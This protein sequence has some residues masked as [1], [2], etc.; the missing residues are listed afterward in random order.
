MASDNRDR[1]RND[2]ILMPRQY[3]MVK[4][5]TKG[6]LS[7]AVGPI[8]VTVSET[9]RL[10]APD[11]RNPARLIEVN[12]ESA[13][14]PYTDVGESDYVV[15]S[16]PAKDER[17]VP[18]PKSQ[19]EMVEL[20]HG[21]K[22]N[23]PGPVSFPLWPFQGV[24][25]IK[26]HQ[27]Q[28]N[29][30][31]VVRVVNDAEAL[32]NWTKSIVKTVDTKGIT[33]PASLS[34]GQLI[35]IKGT[36]VSFYIPPTGLEVVKDNGNKYVRDAVTLE[37]LEYCV[38]V[39]QNGEKRFEQGPKVVFPTATEEFVVEDNSKKFKAT[40]LTA[41]SG[42]HIKVTAPY[43]EGDKTYKVG[44]ELFVTGESTPIYYPRAEH[45]LV[46]YGDRV[47]H[48]ATAIPK[49]EG[50]YVMNRLT[51]E[52]KLVR[53]PKM[54]LPDP[55]FEVIV[56]RILTESQ[57]ALWYPGNNE[58]MALNLS[59]SAA[60]ETQ[61]LRSGDYVTTEDMDRLCSFADSP[62][63]GAYTRAYAAAAA[64]T[65]L[66]GDQVSRKETYTP[67]RTVT[68]NTKYDGAVQINVWTGYAVLVVD[69][70]GNRQIVVG[71]QTVLLEFD[72]ELASMEFSTGKP[73]STD[74]LYKTAYLRVLNNQVS[75][76][77]SA[78]TADDIEVK[79]KT[80]YRVNFL[81]ESKEN[82]FDAE[83]YVKL[84]CDHARS[85]LRNVVKKLGI[86]EFT[87]KY[88]DLVRDTVLGTGT[89]GTTGA[90]DPRPGMTFKENGAHIYDVEVLGLEVGDREI[91]SQL[92]LAQRQTIQD[93]LKLATT[94]RQLTMAVEQE[95]INQKLE[96]LR[97]DSA[98][99]KAQLNQKVL[100]ET[101]ALTMA[102][103]KQ[104]ASAFQQKQAVETEKQKVIDI[105]NQSELSRNKLGIDQKM[106]EEATEMQLRLHEAEQ[107]TKNLASRT[108]AITPDLIAALTRFSDMSLI[109][110]TAEAMAPLAIL[111][112][113]GLK[114]VLSGLLAGTG[115]EK[116]AAGVQIGNTLS[117]GS[118]GRGNLTSV[119]H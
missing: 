40:E 22:V 97:A 62:T 117:N 58:A 110:K 69:K 71:P 32:A 10:M 115:L 108:Q 61:G 114:D 96:T 51:G 67:P 25:V 77:V 81:P 29:Q 38:L 21:R 36:E 101:T 78:Q 49:G 46:K 43:T 7:V 104:E 100:V 118:N 45:A 3:A 31:L 98:M 79:I 82:W 16:N 83:N 99:Q 11:P 17:E 34:V 48:Y 63:S 27:L 119:N 91:A 20:Q 42:L 102:Q 84:L 74:K 2:V 28:M 1:E 59:L 80:S 52:I 112:K 95:A 64:P 109:E 47:K 72:Q 70:T 107:E 41:I 116:L 88:I 14:L 33:K 4:D 50:R 18:K 6:N 13:I 12:Q 5:T 111:N 76:V 86:Q 57:V 73:K 89:T 19:N 23:I 94:Q 92:L 93:A 60:A 65:K 106:S 66:V 56:R 85:K 9:D 24:E 8:K 103:L 75:D 30:Y 90:K 53:G 68:L 39:D 113:S 55:R 26:G 105:A 37:Q 44:D 15:L 87:D 35:I 54:L